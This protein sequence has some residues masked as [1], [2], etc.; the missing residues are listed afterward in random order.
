M[1]HFSRITRIFYSQRP[2]S[3]LN[4][5]VWRLQVRN[6]ME[7]NRQIRI[8]CSDCSV[9]KTRNL[10][11]SFC[12]S[13][14]EFGSSPNNSYLLLPFHCRWFAKVRQSW[15]TLEKVRKSWRTLEKVEKVEIVRAFFFEIGEHL[16]KSWETCGFRSAGPH[17]N[18]HNHALIRPLE[19]L[20]V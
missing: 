13:T 19:E 12:W 4:G 15:R 20:L 17:L 3:L 16:E 14:S 2:W 6:R 5:S 8:D 11:I 10:R 7:E 1:Y 18:L 9:G